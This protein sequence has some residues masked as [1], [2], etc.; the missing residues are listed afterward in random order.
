MVT[1]LLRSLR[2]YKRPTYLT[3]ILSAF[4]ALFETII[5]LWMAK[6]I[7]QGVEE[8]NAEKVL[9]FGGILIL[10]VATEIFFGVAATFQGTLASSGLCANLREDMFKRVQTFSFANIDRFSTA[11]IVTR[12]TTDVT[13]IR[14]A[15]NMIIRLAIRTPV[16]MIFAFLSAYQLNAKISMTFLLVTP[17]VIVG[18]GV[19]IYFAYPMF[20]E[21]F[22]NYDQLNNV[23]QEDV[24]GIRVVKSFDREAHEVKKFNL[25]S[26]MIRKLYT[27]VECIVAVNGPIMQLSMYSAVMII[28]WLGA[29]A[30]VASGNVASQ[31]LTTGTLSALISFAMII[32]SNMMMLSMVFVVILV[33]SASARRIAEILSEESTIQDPPQPL[34]SVRDGEIRFEHVDF[35]Y[36]DESSRQVLKDINLVIPSGATVGLIGATGAAKSSL[37]QLIPRLYDVAAGRVLVGGE[38]VRAYSL[39]ALRGSVAMVLQKNELFSGTVRE[40][41]RWGNEAASDDEIEA[42]CKLACAD[43][44]IREL[45]NGYDTQIDQGGSNVSGGQKQRLCI[46]RALLKKPKILILDDSTSAVD[47][48]TDAIIQ[49]GLKQ[50]IPT[51]TKIII[52]QRVSSMVH[53]DCI[54]VLDE[55][56]VVASGTHEALLESCDIYRDIY[57][58]QQK[59]GVTA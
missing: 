52:S 4:E 16:V 59:R 28:S 43:A 12:L 39:E 5:P 18:L 53:A 21:I 26:A 33:A 11:S 20:K 37:V 34:T 36:D 46:A 49:A 48:K 40:N 51:T 22:K 30:I 38:D 54:V 17:L 7:D 29:K 55:G 15:Y 58:S 35:T 25:V 23:V 8:G 3:A 1:L 6:L 44:F 47:T 50:Y 9:L 19:I 41:L 57:E 13:Y 42:V 56:Q 2:E 45:P 27:R 24:R 31:G 32:L 10:I 14:N